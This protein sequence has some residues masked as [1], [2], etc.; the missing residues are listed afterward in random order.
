MEITERIRRRF[1]N[2]TRVDLTWVDAV[3]TELCDPKLMVIAVPGL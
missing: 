2:V 3:C 1:R